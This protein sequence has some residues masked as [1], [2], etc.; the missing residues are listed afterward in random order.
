MRAIARPIIILPPEL[1]DQIAAGE[2][3][4]RPA[5]VLK[6]LLENSLDAGA[7]DLLIHM[8]DGGQT[9]I[10]VQDNGRGIAGE[11]LELAVTRHA[12]SKIHSLSEL[13]RVNSYGFRGEALS[14]VASVSGLRVTSAAAGQ[15]A[16]FIELLHGRI[17]ARG[18]AALRGGTLVEVRDLFANVP[19]RLKFLKSNATELKR[20]QDILWRLALAALPAGFAFSSGGRELCRLPPKESLP[21]RLSRIWPP[22]V[23][24]AL[25]PLQGEKDGIRVSGLLSLPSS[26]QPRADRL[27]FYVNGRPAADRLLLKVCREAYKGRILSRE[28]PQALLFLELN[29]EEVD[30]NVHPAKSEVRFRDER[31]VFGAVLQAMESALGRE[32]VA[33]PAY[34]PPLHVSSSAGPGYSVPAPEEDPGER[35][36]RPPGFWGQADK[37]PLSVSL[38]APRPERSVPDDFWTA[39]NL[40]EEPAVFSVAPADLREPPQDAPREAE[41]RPALPSVSGLTYLGQ[42]AGTYLA[43][44]REEQLILL[45]QHAVHER[46]LARRLERDAGRNE[47]RLLALPLEL[48]LHRAETE[49]LQELWAELAGLGFSLSS[50]RTDLLLVKAA[51]SLLTAG[52][53]R[54]FL[55][56]ALAGKK[57]AGEGLS[58]LLT[59]MACRGAIKA[60]QRLSRAEALNL[61]RQWLETED[62]DYCPHGR[63]AALVLGRHE[64]EKMFKRKT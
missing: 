40:R 24:A 34:F 11:E 53:A 59:L 32:S 64:L 21:E 4:E 46:I 1:R 28:Y 55:R 5:S 36:A 29:P 57:E 30:V 2:V 48:P 33:A 50:P 61:V 63:P 31:A 62:R 12:T 3:V 18:P 26:T 54:E 49:R 13:L 35:A 44:M 56:E 39:E 52:Q 15:E 8:E 47:A 58:P 42:I 45:D 25:R 19:A 41:T 27:W 17:L 10:S 37:D 9:L 22:Q 38:R 20:C 6:E 51:P 14:S 60:G 43:L 16:A 7:D 23:C